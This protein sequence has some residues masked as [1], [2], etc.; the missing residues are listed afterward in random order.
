MKKCTIVLFC[1][2]AVAGCHRGGLP[3]PD[4]A[5]RFL[6]DGQLKTT[7]S[8]RQ[9]RQ[10]APLETFSAWD[11]YYKRVKRWRAF[12]LRPILEMG[13]P[14]EK[15]DNQEL[16]LRARDGYTVPISGE[17]LLESGAWLAVADDENP[18]WEPIGPQRAEPGPFYLV[19][20]KPEQQNIETHP[21]PW[22]LD[23]IELAKFEA[24][25]PHTVPAGAATGSEAWRGFERFRA[26][27]IRCH[28]VNREGGHIGPE[29]NVPMNILEYRD[30]KWVRAYIREPEKFR[31]GNMPGHPD[32]GETELNE[33]LA[34]LKAMRERKYDPK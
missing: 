29:L 6:K 17:R 2:A 30:E 19:W 24:L 13:F 4:A 5:L 18:A 3:E 8:A 11:P 26:E 31:Y 34:Y 22:A 32:F 25:F 27:C 21:R 16:V 1:A 15:L 7:V 14:G 20:R 12:E 23:A 10:K 33:I 28:A 9:M